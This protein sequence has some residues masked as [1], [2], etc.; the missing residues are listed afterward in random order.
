MGR[1]REWLSLERQVVVKA[2]GFAYEG[3]MYKTMSEV[4]RA[5]CCQRPPK[6]TELWRS[7]L[8]T[9]TALATFFYRGQV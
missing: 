2:E 9:A 5:I 4:A 6:A 7:L 3:K 1:K 8:R